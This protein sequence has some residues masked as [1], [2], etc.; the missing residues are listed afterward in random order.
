MPAGP[1]KK[2]SMNE[3]VA[4][5]VRQ[6]I[7]FALKE[8]L[9]TA[10]VRVRRAAHD[11]ERRQVDKGCRYRRGLCGGNPRDGCRDPDRARHPAPPCVRASR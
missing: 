3:I 9:D 1:A 8:I 10:A 5:V 6:G 11:D 2:L 4:A 7:E